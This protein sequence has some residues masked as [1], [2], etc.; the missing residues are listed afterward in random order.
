MYCKQCGHQLDDNSA[1]CP[2]CGMEKGFGIGFCPNCGTPKTDSGNFCSDCGFNFA[3]SGTVVSSSYADTPAPAPANYVAPVQNN[4]PDIN[5]NY[6]SPVQNNMPNSSGFD[7]KSY[8]LES[9]NNAKSVIAMP[10][11][12]KMG[13]RYGSYAVSVLIF[14]FMLFPVVT[15]SVDAMLYSDSRPFNLFGVSAFGA[16]MYLFAF[17]A[18]LATFLP[19]VQNFIKDN[20]KLEP[21]AYLIVP[22]LE[23]V[24][25]LSFFI[26]IGNAK[27]KIPDLFSDNIKVNMTFL[28]VVIIILSLAGIGAAVYHFIKY[29]LA[30]MKVNNPFVGNV[31]KKPT[32]SITDAMNGDTYNNTV[33]RGDDVNKNNNGQY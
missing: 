6:A 1:S 33:Y 2:N 22:F 19:H 5:S 32:D 20:P 21:F 8:M 12:L 31:S 11:K 10:D 24:G 18:A 16:T 4:I 25:M 28:G 7:F 27:S 3:V 17:L 14:L 15:V 23:L 30:Y 29:D 13:L 9:L 26:G